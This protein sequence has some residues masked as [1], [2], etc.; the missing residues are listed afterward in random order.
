MIAKKKSR[1]LLGGECPCITLAFNTACVFVERVLY[2]RCSTLHPDNGMALQRGFCFVLSL[3][4]TEVSGLAMSSLEMLNLLPSFLL[5]P[6]EQ[7]R[8]FFKKTLLAGLSI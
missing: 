2:Q 1:Q 8:V 6:A 3:G 4:R 5:V 7:N